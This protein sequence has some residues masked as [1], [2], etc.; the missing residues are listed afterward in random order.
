MITKVLT[1]GG[2]TGHFTLLS[3][4]KKH[5]VDI[6]AVV[7]MADD[8]GS[9]GRLRDELGVLPPGDIR[10]CL[11]ALSDSSELLRE[12]MNYRFPITKRNGKVVDG[13]GGHNFGNLLLSALE[14]IT[15]NFTKG[16]E[17]A[18]KILNTKGMVLPVAN[19]EMNLAIKLN[20]GQEIVGE[21]FLDH[22]DDIRHYG[23]KKVSLKP[24]VK[25][26]DKVLQAIRQADVIVLGPGDHYG[27]IIPNLLVKGIPEAINGSKATVIY[28]CNLTNKK[29]QTDGYD[30]ER[31]V[32]E[33]NEY[34]GGN[35][36]DYVIF[37][38]RKPPESLVKKYEKKEGKNSIVNFEDRVKE[39]KYK[40]V[41]ADVTG[42]YHKVGTVR[43]T[44]DLIADSR[45]FIR[46]DSDRLAK[47]VLLVGE[48]KK[49]RKIIKEII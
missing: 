5:D 6:T 44:N 7:S 19:K 31:Y 20:N 8:G 43:G 33:M 1:I 12:L 25:A 18:S 40:V 49:Y 9:T 34:L 32:E 41:L 37:P 39:R 15:G 47:A 3:G 28:N 42:K 23:V 36:V 2:G 22:N 24:L 35:R 29:G 27:S 11:V 17:E 26:N 4:L 38:T 46:H 30:L 10:Q 14:K 21:K 16:A 48:R 13:L 45:S